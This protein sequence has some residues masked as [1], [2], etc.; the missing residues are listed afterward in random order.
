M[1][2]P[3]QARLVHML[4]MAEHNVTYEQ[5]RDLLDHPDPEVRRSLAA[6]A[7]LEPEILYFL[8]QDPDVDVRRTIATNNATPE[9]AAIIL[10]TDKEDDVRIDLADRLAR[11]IPDMP[12]DDRAKTW[13][14]VHQVLSLL[15]RDQLPRV[16]RALSEAL[17][18]IPDAPHDIVLTLARDLEI[19]VAAPILE[20]SPVL[21]DEDLIDIIKSSPLT[22]PL[23]AI[24]RRVNV[25]EEVSKAIVGAG[26][27]DAISSLLRNSSA[28]IR[29]ETLDLIIDTAPM[30]PTWHDPLVNRRNLAGRA[31][32]RIAEF[33]ADSLLKKLAERQDFDSKTTAALAHIVHKRLANDQEAKVPD[34]LDLALDPKALKLAADQANRLA[35]QGKLTVSAVMRLAGEG[36]S[37]QVIAALARRASL[38]VAVVAEVVRAVSPKGMVAVAWAG[39]FEAEDAVQLQIKIARVPPDAVIKPRAGGWFDPTED[40]MEWQL[41]MFKD[42][43]AKRRDAAA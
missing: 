13:R 17:K 28:Q 10:A 12:Q 39:E 11:L 34:E 14:T 8:A 16:R 2:S 24:S 5:A 36:L 23:V 19:A 42:S 20:F 35:S 26:N 43:A 41:S 33:V 1:T 15:V 21:T 27:V 18:T 22:A 32:L 9:K 25:G 7:D 30:Y 6:R 31:A 37:P 40:E 29:E 3:A 38:D 4:G